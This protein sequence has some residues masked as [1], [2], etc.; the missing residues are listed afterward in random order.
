MVPLRAFKSQAEDALQ[1]FVRQYV[2]NEGNTCPHDTSRMKVIVHSPGEFPRASQNFISIPLES[3][4]S[5]TV[6]PIMM[7]TATDLTRYSTETRQCYFNSERSLKFFRF[8][9]RRNCE[10]ECFTNFTLA[11]CGCVKISMPRDENSMPC[12]PE[13]YRCL[14][15]SDYFFR[16]SSLPVDPSFGKFFDELRMDFNFSQEQLA[17]IMQPC[18]CLPSCVSLDYELTVTHSDIAFRENVVG[19]SNL[20]SSVVNVFFKDDSFLKLKRSELY[21]WSDFMANCGG[22]LGEI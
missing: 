19:V 14:Y 13:E 7:T 21:G 15:N 22:L 3:E 20:R 8:Y 9:T 16:M 2:G 10:H 4:V 1:L 11:M 6:K 17:L 12:V 5:V 18:G